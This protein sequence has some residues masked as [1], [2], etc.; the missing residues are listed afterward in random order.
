[1]FVHTRSARLE[2]LGTQFKVETDLASTALNVTEGKVRVKRL[3][4]GRTVDVPA[5]HRVIAAAEVEMLPETIPESV[6]RWKS[7]LHLGPDGT[8]GKWSP[9]TDAGDAK[10]RAVPY[11][12]TTPQGQTF[13]VYVAGLQVSEGDKHPVVLQAGSRIRVRGR[14]KSASDIYFGVTVRRAAG[15]FAGNFF[16]I[17]PAS[18]FESEKEFE[19]VLDLHELQLDPALAHL[20]DELPKSPVDGVI[21]SFYCT[22]AANPAGLEIVEV[23]MIQ[24]NNK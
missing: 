16:A 3:S 7:Q 12:H 5:N 20:K 17:K 23:E 8:L 21:E 24:P 6:R 15:G 10:L 2:V 18:E 11:L 1:M 22:S 14:L 19:V 4:D 9:Q 13:S